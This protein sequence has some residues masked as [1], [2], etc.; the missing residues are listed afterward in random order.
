ME[1]LSLLWASILDLKFTLGCSNQIN[2]WEIARAIEKAIKNK[3]L[4][5]GAPLP[6]VRQVAVHL[7]PVVSKAAVEIA[8]LILKND[9]RLIE[10]QTG[11]GTCV[12]M[13]FPEIE[14]AP[15]MTMDFR[16]HHR[17]ARFNKEFIPP[18]DRTVKGLDDKLFKEIRQNWFPDDYKMGKKIIPQLVNALL[19]VVNSSLCSTYKEDE[20]YYAQ[21]HQQLIDHIC[22]SLM[23]SA[24][25]SFVMADTAP[26]LVREAVTGAGF[27]VIIVQTDSSGMMMENLE[28][29]LS[30]RNVGIVYVRNRSVMPCRQI[31]DAE[32][33]ERLL[34][35][36]LK[37]KFILIEDDQ[38]A[39]FYKDKLHLLMKKALHRK[40]N[41]IYIR[42]VSRVHQA[43]VDLYIVV[44]GAKSIK[45]LIELFQKVGKIVCARFCC[46]ISILFH[47]NIL[48]KYE[49]KMHRETE[50]IIMKARSLLQESGLWKR[51]GLFCENGWFFY[52]EPRCGSLSADIIDRLQKEHIYT[53]D[54]S[55]FD[56]K[57]VKNSIIL[58]IAAYL[59]G[60]HLEDDILRLNEVIHKVIHKRKK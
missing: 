32:S 43:F 46:T 3:S 17:V 50:N 21:D 58:S 41:V 14:T 4:P 47:E 42:P 7:M 51:E 35:L 38:Y 55:N 59:D 18:T 39:T 33:V 34:Q 29:I 15:K 28:E 53:M 54:I 8:W 9:L 6:T 40:S 48:R 27:Q 49:A 11:R 52:L 31:L 44:A 60:D 25:K 2:A 37:F 12:V 19:R 23:S 16:H 45:S 24:R 1:N 26:L 56:R 10:T 30:K 13:A 22:R 20:L 57:H 5:F 36:Q